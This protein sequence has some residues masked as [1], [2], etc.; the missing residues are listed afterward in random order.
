ME[1]FLDF[2]FRKEVKLLPL[3]LNQSLRAVAISLTALFS[4]IFIYKILF[5]LTGD[6]SIALLVVLTYWLGTHVFK[7][8][9]NLLAEEWSLKLGLKKQIY[10]GL[11]FLALCLLTLTFSSKWPL[12]LFLA[13]PLW[14]L[15]IGFYWFGRHGLMAKMGRDG[16]F[17]KELGMVEVINTM[18]LL[19]VP[20]LGGFLINLSGF[21]ALFLVSL[22]FVALSV[23]AL[24]PLEKTRTHHDTSLVEIFGL[25]KTHQRMA[26]AYM[27]RSAA[28]TIY[29]VVIPL[30]LFLILGKELS[31]GAFFSL[32]MIAVALINLMI[33]RWADLKGKKELVVYGSVFQFLVWLGRTLTRG[34]GVLFVFDIID[35][36]T[37]GMVGIPLGVLSYEKALDG[38][39]TGRAVLFR[40]IAITMGETFADCLLIVLVLLGRELQFAFL[41]AAL[42]SLLP[43]LIIERPKAFREKL[44][45]WRTP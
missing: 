42:F 22:V 37:G 20:F 9:S 8:I 34:I 35:R 18:L 30:Y 27:G 41:A 24:K 32:S 39:S 25:F 13:S 14:G 4:T 33:G 29:G 45:F 19:A 17:G 38:H 16:A 11:F 3:F 6:K 12:L 5:H 31:L 7:F 1:R 23:L 43:L 36:V 10:F 40:E 44:L 26:L 28:G 2:Q 15:S 21:K